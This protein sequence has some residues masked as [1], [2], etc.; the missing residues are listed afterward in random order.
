MQ[1]I[2]VKR[3]RLVKV[4]RELVFRCPAERVQ[5]DEVVEAVSELFRFQQE[6][7]DDEEA[8]LKSEEVS[9]V[10]TGFIYY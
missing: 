2:Q 7:L 1:R 4:R 8:D 9:W 5:L 3:A 10:Q 6:E